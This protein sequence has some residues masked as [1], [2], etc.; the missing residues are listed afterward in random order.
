MNQ[1]QDFSRA[2][3]WCGRENAKD[4]AMALSVEAAELC[5]I[6][7]WLHSDEA[8]S[9]K[10]NIETYEHLRDELADVFWYTCRIACHFGVDLA[11]AVQKKAVKN[12]QKYPAST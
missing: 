3:G 5:E 1:I 9:V 12:A 4:L 6:F 8:D 7:M 11:A 10:N 2:R